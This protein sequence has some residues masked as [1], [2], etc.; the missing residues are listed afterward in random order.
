M[1]SMMLIGGIVGIQSPTEDSSLA[2]GVL[3]L[4][5]S[6]LL[7][8][9]G[10]ARKMFII[11]AYLSVV[12]ER[13]SPKSWETMTS[14]FARRFPLFYETRMYALIYLLVSTAFAYLI[15]P[16]ERA[17]SIFGLLICVVLCISLYVIP[18]RKKAFVAQWE[19]VLREAGR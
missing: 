17:I 15:F 3:I 1:Y 7:Y 4:L 13:P 9:V 10:A 2:G 11:G 14:R 5:V 6:G 19:R 18:S 16:Y 8:L 12:H